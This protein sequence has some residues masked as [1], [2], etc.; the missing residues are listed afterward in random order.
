LR[1]SPLGLAGP[2]ALA[3]ALATRA[4]IAAAQEVKPPLGRCPIHSA[5]RPQSPVV[6]SPRADPPSAPSDAVVQVRFRTIRIRDIPA[7]AP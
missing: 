7:E 1:S 6:A 3:I 5:D 2:L 4:P